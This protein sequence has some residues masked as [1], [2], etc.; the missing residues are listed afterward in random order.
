M[1]ISNSTWKVLNRWKREE[2]KTHS[3]KQT[4]TNSLPDNKIIQ[5][6]ITDNYTF[7]KK[8]AKGVDYQFV[9]DSSGSYVPS[10]GRSSY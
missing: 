6:V 10:W 8:I 9:L 3:R 7:L 5:P 2:A 4:N 1:K